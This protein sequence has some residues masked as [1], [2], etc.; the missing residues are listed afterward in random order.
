[1][2]SSGT[3]QTIALNRS[4]RCVNIT[5]I[6]RPPFDPPIAPS[7]SFDVIFRRDQVL[8]H[9]DEVVIDHLPL[10]LQPRLVPGRPELAAAA[11]VGQHIDPAL[12]QPQ[13]AHR[14]R[15]V[16]R[17]AHLE[18]AIAV[19]QRRV[20]A[21]ELHVRLVH[22]EVGHLRPVLRR[23]LILVDLVGRSIEPGRQRL[24]L[25]QR[26]ARRVVLVERIRL[27]EALEAEEGSRLRFIGEGHAGRAFLRQRNLL[28]R[29]AFRALR[30]GEHFQH[31]IVRQVH[32]HCALGDAHALDRLSLRRAHHQLHLRQLAGRD[33][34]AP[35]EPDQVA[36]PERL[37][38]LP[39]LHLKA[40]S[41]APASPAACRRTRPAASPWAAAEPAPAFHP[42]RE[43]G[44]SST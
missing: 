13:L 1:M 28:R 12:L 34:L 22:D 24:D 35:S 16:R 37:L 30:V 19:Q 33:E 21:V 39:F 40:S 20:R 25:L 5:P 38:P 41:P 8:G 17:I 10:G 9:R 7:F 11:D 26:A 44:R 29:P 27:Q 23:R 32:Q 3:W 42:S 18:S 31:D 2:S 14:A 15:I 4:G 43:T 6:S 36:G